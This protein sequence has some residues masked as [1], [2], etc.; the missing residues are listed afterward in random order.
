[1][2]VSERRK[3]HIMAFPQWTWRNASWSPAQ[4]STSSRTAWGGPPLSALAPSSTSVRIT[5][6]M[7]TLSSGRH[8][9][10]QHQKPHEQQEMPVG[11]GQLDAQR[12]TATTAGAQKRAHPE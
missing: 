10:P 6:D 8:E 2:K 11:G 4:S 7:P 12:R 5:V 1:M 9:Q 3:I